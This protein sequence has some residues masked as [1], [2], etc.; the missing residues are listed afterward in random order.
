[1]V[2]KISIEE[3]NAQGSLKLARM[4]LEVAQRNYRIAA[5]RMAEVCTRPKEHHQSS[6]WSPLDTLGNISRYTNHSLT[7]TVCS[8]VIETWTTADKY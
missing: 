7:C 6:D 8:K 5:E 4:A 3:V 1:M 2:T